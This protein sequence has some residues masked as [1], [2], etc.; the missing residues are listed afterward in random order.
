MA[1]DA[2]AGEELAAMLEPLVRRIVCRVLGPERS[3]E[4]DDACQ[5]ALLRIL[6]RLSTWR[7]ECPLLGWAAVVAS[8]R[9][10]DVKY[11]RWPFTL[12]NEV[13]S[14]FA[15][16]SPSGDFELGECIERVISGFPD[17]WK[18]VLQLHVDKMNHAEIA[19][20]V[21]KSRRTVQYWLEKMRNELVRC[22]EG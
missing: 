12:P 20:T 3:G 8:R 14:S 16:A 11:G 15:E 13:L 10:L 2:A 4:R 22:V 18:T 7:A 21:G 17:L 1:G 6:T 19:E 5:A 9:A